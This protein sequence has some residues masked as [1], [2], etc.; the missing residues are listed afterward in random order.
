M[1]PKDF[2]RA[3]SVP[4]HLQ[5]P[6][7]SRSTRRDFIPGERRSSEQDAPGSTGSSA[8][9]TGGT[10]SASLDASPPPSSST[11]SSAA[12]ESPSSS[13]AKDMRSDELRDYLM[14]HMGYKE[15]EVKRLKVAEMRSLV[16]ADMED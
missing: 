9:R 7:E 1:S 3:G 15:D 5:G 16:A 12:S 4:R 13:S 11:T 2:Y 10:E 6:I 14:E 8:S